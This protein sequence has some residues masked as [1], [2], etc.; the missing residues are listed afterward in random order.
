M[1]QLRG[2]ETRWDDK[3]GG[4]IEMRREKWWNSWV[5]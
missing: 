3:K 4:T 2:L 1:E 5:V